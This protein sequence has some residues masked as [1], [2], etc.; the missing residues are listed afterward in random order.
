MQNRAMASVFSTLNDIDYDKQAI[1]KSMAPIHASAASTDREKR[2]SLTTHKK[3]QQQPTSS[4]LNLSLPKKAKDSSLDKGPL[5]ANAK[6]RKNMS[7]VKAADGGVGTRVATDLLARH[8][9][10]KAIQFIAEQAEKM[11]SAKKRQSSLDNKPA[12][13]RQ[14]GI[15][16]FQILD[17]AEDS[18]RFRS[19]LEHFKQLTTEQQR[20]FNRGSSIA[21][22]LQN[23]LDLPGMS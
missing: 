15:P 4:R 1:S 18:I 9:S 12:E 8:P 2:V 13:T 5:N 11:R 3:L 10:K 17:N 22:G 7:S 20:V 6:I 23:S 21:A 19:K 16:Q 14:S